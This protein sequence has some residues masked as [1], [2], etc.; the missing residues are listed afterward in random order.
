MTSR[1]VPASS[2][3][4]AASR[5]AS[6][7]RRLDLPA[8][9]APAM[10]TLN[11]SRRRS[12]LLT[13]RW[14]AIAARSCADD[15][16]GLRRDVGDHVALVGEVE[17]GFDQRLRA[18]EFR[19][20]AFVERAQRPFG[21]RQRLAALRFRLGVDEIGKSLDLGQVELAVLEGAA[22]ELAGLGEARAGQREHRADHSADHRAAAM[23]VKLGHV[24]AGEARRAFE[25]EDEAAIDE[26]RV[27]EP[28][29]AQA[30]V[31][32]RG[33]AAAQRIEHGARVRTGDT[34]HGDGRETN[35]ARRRDD[36]VGGVHDG[37]VHRVGHLRSDALS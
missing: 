1:V 9:G 11:P 36:R 12:P 10:T 23:H 37:P 29:R 2:D 25:P 34:D 31:A 28:D 22:R 32:G 21:L 35:A 14:R 18:H 6:A 5:L 26:R 8:L 17:T 24:F 13:A 19:A 30:R 20:P 16:I 33:H 4:I 3:T 27:R 15:R 7:F